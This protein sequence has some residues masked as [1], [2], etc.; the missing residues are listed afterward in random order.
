[1]RKISRIL[2]L[3]WTGFIGVGALYGSFSMII[4]PTGN[5]LQMQDMLV[6]FKKMPFYE[7]LFK[8][9]LFSGIALFIV[10]GITNITA[11]I[12]ILLNKKIGYILGMV[13]GITLMV[14]IGIQF[15]LFAPEVY[16]LDVIFMIFGF[17]QFVCGL[18]AYVRYMQSIFK[19]DIL[20]YEIQN[21]DVAVVYFSREGYTRK[22]AYEKARELQCK[23]IEVKTTEKINGNVGFWWCGRFAIHKWEMPLSSVDEDIKSFKK[24]YIYCPI[25]ALSI[26][27][28][29]RGFIKKYQNDI[30][31]VDFTI[32]HF[33]DANY[34]F[35]FKEVEDILANKIIAKHSISSQYGINKTLY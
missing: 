5:L 10:N 4:D 16:A 12:L 31:H 27:S 18:L 7:I 29:I 1:M 11:F 28:P 23:L 8:D 19:F 14:W 25:W 6:Y 3:F 24:L 32:I 2:I 13:F 20:D 35:A 26:C 33:M 30:N 22:I 15:Y 21:N 9:Y 34:D 17:L